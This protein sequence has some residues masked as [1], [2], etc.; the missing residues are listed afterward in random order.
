VRTLKRYALQLR[1]HDGAMHTRANGFVRDFV[2]QPM[3][4]DFKHHYTIAASIAD[5]AAVALA[6]LALGMVAATSFSRWLTR[7]CSVGRNP[8]NRLC[9]VVRE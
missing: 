1:I 3:R 5:V 7:P 4:E 8:T 6:V 9:D 2:Q